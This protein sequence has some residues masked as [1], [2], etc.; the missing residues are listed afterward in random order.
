[1]RLY[2]RVRAHTRSSPQGTCPLLARLTL[3][4]HAANS[5]AHGHGGCRGRSP[6]HPACCGQ[7][8]Q[9]PRHVPQLVTTHT[10]YAAAGHNSAEPAASAMCYLRAPGGCTSSSTALCMH[11]RVCMCVAVPVCPCV[12]ACVCVSVCACACASLWLR[13]CVYLHR[14]I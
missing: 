14:A 3:T 6:M 10:A 4:L 2:V 1:M 12:A 7:S 9:R 5:S 8:Q 11:L 13:A